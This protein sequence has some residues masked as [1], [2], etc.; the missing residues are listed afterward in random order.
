MPNLRPRRIMA[1]TLLDVDEAARAGGG[2]QIGRC[3]CQLVEQ[4]ASDFLGQLRLGQMKQ[5]ALAAALRAVGKFGQVQ[6]G[7]G[8]EDFPGR[9][10]DLGRKSQVAGIVVDHGAGFGWSGKAESRSSLHGLDHKGGKFK[11][12]IGKGLGFCPPFRV[13]RKQFG[14]AA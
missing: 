11:E 9:T 7:D 2:H 13:I 14:I 12:P 5:A 4:P 1:Q 6:A 10:G 8:P 3:L